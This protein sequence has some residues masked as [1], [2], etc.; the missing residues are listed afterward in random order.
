MIFTPIITLPT[1]ILIETWNYIISFHI[2]FHSE[3]VKFGSANTEMKKTG[4][5][6]KNNEKF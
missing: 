5:L 4:V 1:S 2:T 6:R 3:V